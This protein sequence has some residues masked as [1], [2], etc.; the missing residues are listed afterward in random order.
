MNASNTL[1]NLAKALAA[2]QAEIEGAVRDSAN[3][4]FKSKYAD[5]SS[6][7]DACRAALTKNGLAVIQ[8]PKAKEATVTVT[9]MLLHESGEW[10]AEELTATAKDD[11]PQAV[12]SIITYLRRYGLS[13]MVG[14]APEDDDGESAQHRGPPRERARPTPQE[15]ISDVE[16]KANAQKLARVKALMALHGEHFKSYAFR[17]LGREVTS[18]ADLTLGDI[19]QLEEK[20]DVP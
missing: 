15:A 4:F 7:W 12:G 16:A 13:S 17:I 18:S 3:P 5:L 1:G 11:S 2:A 8:A 6:V 19:A 20:G 10:V 14:V 9:T